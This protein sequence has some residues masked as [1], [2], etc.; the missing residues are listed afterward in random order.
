MEV[1]KQQL[2]M[3]EMEKAFMSIKAGRE[4][5][6]EEI[7]LIYFDKEKTLLKKYKALQ[8]TFEDHKKDI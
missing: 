1:T 6:L 3:E 4:T 8:I 2:K 7:K 5:E